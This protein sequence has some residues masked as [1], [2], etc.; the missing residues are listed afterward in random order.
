MTLLSP[1]FPL[2]PRPSRGSAVFARASRVSGHALHRSPGIQRAFTTLGVLLQPRFLI[3][4][5]HI[6]A[7][8]IIYRNLVTSKPSSTAV[9][10][11]LDRSIVQLRS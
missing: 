6:V 7:C 4:Y 2:Y 9:S 3:A 8:G 11:D 5:Q 1:D 10:C